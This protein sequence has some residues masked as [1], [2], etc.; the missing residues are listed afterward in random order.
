MNQ[1]QAEAL[2]AIVGGEAWQS[3]GDIWVVTRHRGDGRVIAFSGDCV[4]VD[5][6]M[7]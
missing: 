2:A 7:G 5:A 4:C 6:A 1:K 3:G